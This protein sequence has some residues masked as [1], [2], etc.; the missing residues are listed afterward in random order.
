[1]S[2]LTDSRERQNDRTGTLGD[3]IVLKTIDL[4]FSKQ[5]INSSQNNRYIVL[6]TIFIIYL[7]CFIIN[8]ISYN[9]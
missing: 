1:M 7:E 2:M 5:Y 6:K 8:I 9:I 4:L 3:P